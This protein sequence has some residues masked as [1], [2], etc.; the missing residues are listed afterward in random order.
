MQKEPATLTLEQLAHPDSARSVYVP[1][2]QRWIARKRQVERR[3]A[4]AH[5][6]WP[7]RVSAFARA[8]RQSVPTSSL[9]TLV[10]RRRIRRE[11]RRS[12]GKPWRG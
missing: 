2:Q 11:I 12:A 7:K 9:A 8:G 10:L 4:L 5:M 3:V 6:S 1:L